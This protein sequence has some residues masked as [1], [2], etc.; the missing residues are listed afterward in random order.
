MTDL[1]LYAEA[2]ERAQWALGRFC[3]P[4]E[5]KRDL[6]HHLYLYA[7]PQRDMPDNIIRQRMRWG[8]LDFLKRFRLPFR[9]RHTDRLPGVH[10][11]AALSPQF[12]VASAE[13][14]LEARIMLGS[15][16]RPLLDGLQAGGSNMWA[17]KK[18]AR[19]I[20]EAM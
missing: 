3:M 13:G 9:M 6:Q 10:S 14:A 5:Q 18:S 4:P 8:V 19:R 7:L 17:L 11:V 2:W 15:L 1:E 16:P 12:A 20:L